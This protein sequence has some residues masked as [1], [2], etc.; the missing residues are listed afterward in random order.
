[1]M[2]MSTNY[3]GIRLK[4]PLV[5]SPSPLCEDV[6][7][8]RR[9]EDAGAAAVVLHSLFEEQI[10]LESRELD[11]Y[12]TQG[13]ERF[14]E[15]L[16]YFPDLGSYKLGPDEYLEHIH[17]AQNSVDIP[18]IGSLNGVSA[19][20]W[21]G[22]AEEIEEAGADALELNIYYIP[23][24]SDMTSDQVEQIYIDL[25]K[26]VKENISIPVAVKL[27]PYFSSMPNVARQLDQAGADALVLFNRF[28]QPDLDIENLEVAPN[29]VLSTSNELRLRLR[30]VAILFGHIR[31]DMAVTGGVH[32]AEDA[33]KAMMAGAKVAMMTSALLKNS[34]EH[35]RKVRSDILNWMEEHEYESIH[36]MQG[37]MS[38]WTVTDPT[39]FER[40]NYM[41][42][43]SSYTLL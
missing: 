26:A 18:V 43:L 36:Q 10:T 17:R 35:L 20:G 40:A 24:S 23:T 31:A 37:T 15:S 21:I 39:A 12:L 22:Y 4:N 41:K 30:W 27:S 33:L 9:M 16:T 34:I 38:Q 6:D 7:N 32:T 13:T 5:A 25:V 42:V 28:Y 1:M 19:G 2:D 11:R 3:M 29:L 14:A 8:I